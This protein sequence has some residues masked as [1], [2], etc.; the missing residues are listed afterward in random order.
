MYIFINICLFY[1]S[2]EEPVKQEKRIS[3]PIDV[4]AQTHAFASE[5]KETDL[6]LLDPE[7]RRL[8]EEVSK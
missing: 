3:P 7:D 5:V 2:V 4:P 8:V 6:T 1:L